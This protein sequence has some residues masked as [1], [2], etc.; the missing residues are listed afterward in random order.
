MNNFGQVTPETLSLLLNPQAP[1]AAPG[2][3]GL[4]TVPGM[5]QV[6]GM[7]MPTGPTQA[8]AD[9]EQGY[10]DSAALGGAGKSPMA[11]ILGMEALKG[12]QAGIN[13][14]KQLSSPAPVAPRGNQVKTETPHNAGAIDPRL[15]MMM[16]GGK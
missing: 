10:A 8:H 2:I 5:G 6:P 7:E 15:Y 4:S 9:A 3:G 1:G 12:L 13:Q 16:R 11:A 14:P